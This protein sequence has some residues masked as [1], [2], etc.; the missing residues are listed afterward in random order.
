MKF[1][2]EK[3]RFFDNKI[4]LVLIFCECCYSVSIFHKYFSTR[5]ILE[6]KRNNK[7]KELRYERTLS[8]ISLLFIRV[9]NMT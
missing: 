2:L 1:Y 5:L 6:Y 8:V 9:G 7:K 4:Y 3:K